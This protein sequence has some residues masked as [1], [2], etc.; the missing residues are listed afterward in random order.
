MGANT[1]NVAWTVRRKRAVSMLAVACGL[2]WCGSGVV[3]AQQS[4]GNSTSTGGGG[5]MRMRS[6]AG[7]QATVETLARDN[8][9]SDTQAIDPGTFSRLLE[10]V[11]RLHAPAGVHVEQQELVHLVVAG[12]SLE[13]FLEASEGG[14]ELFG[15]T[16]NALD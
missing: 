13:A 6:K 15:T 3:F 8:V 1:Q 11:R 4:D 9:S 16:F 7:Q 5:G 12:Q 10:Q 14:D 2:L